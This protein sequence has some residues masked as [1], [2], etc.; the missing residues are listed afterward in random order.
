MELAV[1]GGA[2]STAWIAKMQDIV[3]CGKTGTAENPHGA[4]H[5]IFVAFAPKDDPQIAIAA[6]VENEGFGSTWA[7]PIASLMIERYLKKEVKRKWLE[8]HVKKGNTKK[9]DG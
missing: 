6:Y 5:S 8:Q 2:G 9:E 7:A 1:N 4:D 3:I